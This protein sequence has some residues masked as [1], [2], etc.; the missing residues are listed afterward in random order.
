MTVTD[1]APQVRILGFGRGAANTT[2]DFFNESALL[3]VL[4]FLRQLFL[5]C[6]SGEWDYHCRVL[7][8]GRE[9]RR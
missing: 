5:Y 1:L 7:K 4:S 6:M 8:P 9:T 3:H 2:T